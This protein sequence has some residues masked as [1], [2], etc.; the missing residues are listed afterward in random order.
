[1]KKIIVL[2]ILMTA[3]DRLRGPKGEPGID[4]KSGHNALIT[5]V[6]AAPSCNNGGSIMLSG[7]DYNDDGILQSG[8]VYSSVVVCNGSDGHPGS[9]GVDGNNGA[10]GFTV[11]IGMVDSAHG[12]GASCSTGGI[13]ILTG[14]DSSRDG[15][16]Q[17]I[18]TQYS[19]DVCNGAVG[20]TGAQGATGAAGINAPVNPYDIVNIVDPCG[21]APNIFD[22]VFLKLANG[23]MIASVSD[24]ASGANTRFSVIAPGSWRTTDGSMCY[25]T[26]DANGNI[27][28]ERY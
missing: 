15:I 19:K 3:C 18:E 1:M 4:G 13:T 11:L 16:L 10:D 28:N 24:N 17:P 6:P 20:A 12:G 9:N 26:I 25:F 2:L 14:V 7:T 5:M 8:E 27:Y 21:D 23:K 22:E